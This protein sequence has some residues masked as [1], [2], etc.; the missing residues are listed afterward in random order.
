[1][2]SAYHIQDAP[3]PGPARAPHPDGGVDDLD[4]DERAGDG[5]DPSAAEEAALGG[6]ADEAAGDRAQ[7]Q[8]GCTLERNQS[9]FLR[10]R[11]FTV[12]RKE[13]R[14]MESVPTAKMKVMTPRQ[15]LR[16]ILLPL[17]LG[18]DRLLELRG[19]AAPDGSMPTKPLL[20]LLLPPAAVLGQQ[21]LLL[22]P[23]DHSRRR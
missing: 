13:K 3:D 16:I 19:M 7:E 14:E 12:A 21:V 4:G 8:T 10:A 9:Y 5:A 23:M 2:H 22:L 17:V 15:T 11:N 20:L 6:Q 18:R 1:V